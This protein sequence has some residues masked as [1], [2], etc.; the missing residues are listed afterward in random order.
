MIEDLAKLNDKYLSYGETYYRLEKEYYQYNS[1]VIAFDFDNTVYDFH[2]LGD[3]YLDVIELLQR[4][5]NIGCYLI[6][7]TANPNHEFI[8]KH[9]K[10]NNIPFDSI[11]IDPPFL[12]LQTGRKIYYNALL[13]D[14]AGLLEVYKQLTALC[15]KVEIEKQLK[16]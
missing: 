10:D 2:Q 1:L 12:K 13:D 16:V 9:L 11:N 5:S 3:T 15:N 4:L 8:E 6:C 7:F 14:R